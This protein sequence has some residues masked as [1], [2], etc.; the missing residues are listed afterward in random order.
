MKNSLQ[1]IRHVALD[2][3]GTIYSGN[4]LFE[5]TKPFLALLHELNVGHTFLTN[6]PSKSVDDYILHLK[7]M[8]IAADENQIYTSTQSTIEYLLQNFPRA[9]KLFI[10]GTPAM[11]QEFT[12]AGFVL[13][14]DDPLDV[15]EALVVGFD[16]TLTYPR[17][18][19]AAWW[20]KLGLPFIATNPDRICPTDQPTV[21]VDCGSICACLEKAT[22]RPPTKVL[23]KPDPNMLRGILSRHGLAP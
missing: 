7:K 14:D 19:R 2:L 23:G 5:S 16:L 12:R 1:N 3:D 17:L 8:S 4:T 6:N 15:P 9:K 20:I 13:A 22:G 21:L 11:G 18:C 10:L